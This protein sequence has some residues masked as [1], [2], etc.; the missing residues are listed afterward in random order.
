MLLHAKY[1][2]FAV[3]AQVRGIKQTLQCAENVT[4]MPKRALYVNMHGAEQKKLRF[5]YNGRKGAGKSSGEKSIK[6]FVTPL[7]CSLSFLHY[8]SHSTMEEAKREG[9]YQA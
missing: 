4:K 9:G 5:W 1:W 7:S 2:H 3:S 8:P 6:E